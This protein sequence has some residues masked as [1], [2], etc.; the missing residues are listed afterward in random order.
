V[1]HRSPNAGR[2]KGCIPWNKGLVGDDRCKHSDDYKQSRVGKSSGRGATPEREAERIRKIT[3]S[4]LRRNG[5]YRVGSGR[6]KKGWYKGFFCDSSYELAYIVFCLD[7]QIRIQRNTQKRQYVWEG[8][9]RNYIPDFVVDGQIIEIKGF[10][11]PQW[12][13]KLKYNP[14]VVVL[15]ERD[16]RLVFDYVAMKYGKDFVKLYEQGA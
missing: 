3:D 4:A 10:K 11:S 6:G 13:A 14:D 2:Q 16:L 7:H 8:K 15:Y 12:E 1:R 5:G 9:Q